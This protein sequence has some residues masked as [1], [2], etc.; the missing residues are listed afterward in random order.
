V[1]LPSIA[2]NSQGFGPSGQA[3]GSALAAHWQGI[4]E[5]IPAAAYTC[6]ASGC[7]TYFN[8][9]AEAV[10]GRAPK[11]RDTRE[12]YC[13]SY[14]L[15][16]PD[17]TPI[18]HEQCWMALALREGRAYGGR[19]IVIERLDGSRT[20]GQAH[21]YPLRG[22]QGQ[23]I[24]AVNLVADLGAVRDPQREGGRP[25]LSAALPQDAVMAMIEIAV[26][27]LAGMVWPA[28]AFD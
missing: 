20:L 27:V 11:L 15:H 22:D 1:R 23:L 21:A 2:D 19:D 6:D 28:A 8:R 5:A 14:R 18:L 24:G 26:A 10:W 7:I 9:I 25:R 12:R 17:G 16:L 4:L 3:D 13:G